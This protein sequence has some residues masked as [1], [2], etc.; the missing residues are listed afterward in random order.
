MSDKI[1]NT[2]IVND[3]ALALLFHQLYEAKAPE[4]GYETKEETKAFDPESPNGKLMI[5]VA[6]EINETVIKP[7][8]E[9]AA[10][11]MLRNHHKALFEALPVG[12]VDAFD[13]LS[14]V[15][16]HLDKVAQAIN[17]LDAQGGTTV[18]EI[19]DDLHTEESK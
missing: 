7:A 10:A 5:A 17:M 8:S 9:R 2:S 13:I 6:H 19:I 4:F 11:Y 14:A 12:D 16:N 3:E 15:N 18:S 1:V